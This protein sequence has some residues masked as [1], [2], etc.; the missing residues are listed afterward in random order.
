[1]KKDKENIVGDL[2]KEE[3]CG[4]VKNIDDMKNIDYVV[5]HYCRQCQHGPYYNSCDKDGCLRT[6]GLPNFTPKKEE[7][8]D[9]P[10]TYKKFDKCPTCE[11]GYLALDDSV[12]LGQCDACRREGTG[13][14][15][16][17]PI[18]VIP[19][20]VFTDAALRKADC[21]KI[22]CDK[23]SWDKIG[24]KYCDVLCPRPVWEERM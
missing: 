20:T 3:L 13:I 10:K 7:I 9:L 18:E 4:T 12:R 8:A 22:S 6:N 15:F 24:G 17:K 2:R 23:I 5:D 16:P 14:P 21:D 11:K 19:P 1:M